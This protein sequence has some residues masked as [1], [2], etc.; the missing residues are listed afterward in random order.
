[1]IRNFSQDDVVH[2]GNSSII[3]HGANENF[4]H[5]ICQKII[6]Q[7]FPTSDQSWYF[8]NEFEFS[9]NINCPSVRKALLKTTVENHKGIVFEYIDGISLEQLK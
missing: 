9:S 4:Y 2:Q 7:E 3:I 6:N 8:E 1:M 5:P